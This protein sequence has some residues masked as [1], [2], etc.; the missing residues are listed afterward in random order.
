MEMTNY[1]FLAV[2][3]TGALLNSKLQIAIEDQEALIEA[4]EEYGLR[5]ALLGDAPTATHLPLI[6]QLRLGANSGYIVSHS[7]AVVFNCRTKRP[8][9]SRPLAEEALSQLYALINDED[10]TVALIGE[11]ALYTNKQQQPRVQRLASQWQLPIVPLM[12]TDGEYP[13]EPVFRL[14]VLARHDRIGRLAEDVKQLLASQLECGPL[15]E[16]SSELS[17]VG[18]GV[19]LESAVEFL[20][21]RLDLSSQSLIAVGAELADVTLIQKSGLGV[22]MANAPEPLKSCADYVTTSCDDAGIARLIAK[23]IKVRY[24]GVPF[25]PEDANAIMPQT[26]MG[27]L[28]MRCTTIA[29]GYV[30]GTMPVDM[31]TRQPMGV[32]HGGASLAFAETL[33]GLGSVAIADEGEI[34]VGMQV[35]GYHV[36]STIEGDVVRGEATILHQGRSTHVWNVDIFSTQSGKLVCTCKVINSILKRR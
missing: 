18:C 25:T 8:V 2:K 34:Q 23:H 27:T 28:G 11:Q 36:S 20:L 33:A 26:L 19:G 3:T 29:R 17:I 7:G 10:Y 6:D 4:Q 31:R 30:T 35:S 16:E 13:A 5:V 15:G 21:D 22:A 1:K 32:L 9:V 14:L 24:G 12:L